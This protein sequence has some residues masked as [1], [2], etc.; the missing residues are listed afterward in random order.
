VAEVG[1]ELLYRAFEN[2]IR[3]AVKYT[4][5][6]STVDI[7]VQAS[8]ST[9]Q[10]TV[11]DRG[12]GVAEAELARMFEPYRR[13]DERPGVAGFGLGL[14]IARRAIESH[15]GQISASPRVGGG[16]CMTLSLPAQPA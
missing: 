4:A 12:P 6:G 13:L 2:V 5:P 9:L 8:P 1:A 7:T 15:G 11:A 10:V 3:N 16:L 14:A